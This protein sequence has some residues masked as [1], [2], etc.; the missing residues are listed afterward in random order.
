VNTC[1]TKV[2]A[3]SNG[4]RPSYHDCKRRASVERS[5]K[6]YC[7]QH[8]PEAISARRELRSEKWEVKHRAEVERRRLNDAAPDLLDAVKCLRQHLGLFCGPDD[9]VAN[10]IFRLVDA[11][12]ARATGETK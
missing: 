4:W 1:C 5:G 12:I 8:D 6:W 11:A 9:A 10:E 3:E 7:A 2:R